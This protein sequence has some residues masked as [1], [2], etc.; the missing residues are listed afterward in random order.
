MKWETP[1]AIDFRFGME[2]TM[3]VSNR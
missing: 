3:Y 1:T 2:I